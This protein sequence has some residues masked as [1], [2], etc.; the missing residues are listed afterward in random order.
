MIGF[1]QK[2]YSILKTEIP[3]L[4]EIGG[5]YLNEK[6]DVKIAYETIMNHMKKGDH[7]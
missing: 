5:N 4:G 2:V 7:K 3:M 6:Y 1:N